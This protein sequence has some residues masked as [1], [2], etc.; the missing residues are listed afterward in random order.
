[1]RHLVTVYNPTD[2]PQQE[3]LDTTIVKA[4]M[5]CKKTAEVESILPSMLNRYKEGYQ[6]SILCSRLHGGYY[7]VSM[8]HAFL[9]CHY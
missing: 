9:L 2:D 8:S 5:K 3:Y 6:N 7:Y 4:L 1:M